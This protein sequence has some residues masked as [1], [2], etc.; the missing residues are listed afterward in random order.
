MKNGL[1]ERLYHRRSV[2]HLQT[3]P[4]AQSKSPHSVLTGSDGH[5]LLVQLW[6]SRFSRSSHE[7]QQPAQLLP[8]AR[9]QQLQTQLQSLQRLFQLAVL[10]QTHEAGSAA[11]APLGCGAAAVRLPTQQLGHGRVHGRHVGRQQR[12]PAAVMPD[13]RAEQQQLPRGWG[14]IR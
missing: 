6:R 14:P 5:H 1:G 3:R 11:A 4:E 10:C 12:R 13:Q 9:G 8:A 2:L 7:G